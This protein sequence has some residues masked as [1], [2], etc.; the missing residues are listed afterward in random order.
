MRNVLFAIAI[1]VTA[2]WH[3]GQREFA[4]VLYALL[5]ATVVLDAVGNMRYTR[6]FERMFAL[7]KSSSIFLGM[8]VL[9]R[10]ETLK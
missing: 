10:C 5:K 8:C 1:S 6:L 4:I 9:S 7:S 2:F 3:V